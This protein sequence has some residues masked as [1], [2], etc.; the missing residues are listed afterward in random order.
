MQRTKR[1]GE[2]VKAVKPRSIQNKKLESNG[3]HSRA[4]TGTSKAEMFRWEQ[5]KP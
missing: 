5:D 3:G 4:M 2:I 1:T